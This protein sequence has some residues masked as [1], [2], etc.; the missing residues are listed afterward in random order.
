MFTTKRR[1]M[2]ITT[3]PFSQR[4]GLT[5]RSMHAA[6]S[7]SAVASARLLTSLARNRANSTRAL[8]SDRSPSVRDARDETASVSTTSSG[9]PRGCPAASGSSTD[10]AMRWRSLAYAS[11]AA[12]LAANSFEIECMVLSPWLRRDARIPWRLVRRVSRRTLEAGLGIGAG[13][14]LAGTLTISGPT[15]SLTLKLLQIGR[16]QE[17]STHNSDLL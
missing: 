16:Q 2:T 14:L 9:I 11:S 4:N 1:R 3:A 13:A 8:A 6:F 17:Q 5:V 7:P 12:A 10:S 15:P